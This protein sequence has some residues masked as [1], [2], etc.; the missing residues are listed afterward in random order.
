MA[1]LLRG[2]RPIGDWS[3]SMILSSWSRPSIRSCGAGTWPLPIS[4][5]LAALY[6]VSMIRV[7]L[8]PPDTPVMT[9]NVPSGTSAVTF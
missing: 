3:M 2:V 7:D 1:G 5:R 4:R 9:Q 8:P 6:S